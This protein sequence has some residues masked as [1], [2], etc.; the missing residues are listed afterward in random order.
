MQLLFKLG[1]RINPSWM[2]RQDHS[3]ALSD[4]VETEK[5]QWLMREGIQFSEKCEI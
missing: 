3:P 4:L 5:P 1:I 2:F